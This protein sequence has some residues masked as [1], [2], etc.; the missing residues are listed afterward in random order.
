MKLRS[1]RVVAVAGLVIALGWPSVRASA[2][3]S[4]ARPE[5]AAAISVPRLIQFN[6]T[7]KDSAGRYVT[8]VS[9]VTF[10]VYAEQ[11]GGSPIWSETQNVLA[12]SDGHFAVLLGAA[13]TGAFPSALFSTTQTRWLGITVARQPEMPRVLLASVPYALKAGDADTLGGLPATSYVTTAQLA[14]RTTVAAP[15]TTVMPGGVIND[16]AGIS[17]ASTNGAPQQFGSG[18]QDATTGTGTANYLP[19]WTSSSNLGNSI[20]YQANGRIGVGT[21]SPQLTLDVNGDSIFRGSFQLPPQATATPGSG[22]PSHSFQWESS[23]YNSSTSSAQNLAFGFRAVPA[24]NN[25][26]NPTAKLDLFYG[27]GGGTLLDTGLSISNA[28][29][30]TF[31]QEQSLTASSV[32]LPNS[33]SG[34]AESLTIGGVGFLGDYGGSTNTFL[35]AKSGG[36]QLSTGTADTAIG[37][38]S[39]QNNTTGGLNVAVG[40]N[41]LQTN[42]TG[43]ANTALGFSAMQ[44]NTS[45]EGN[46]GIG[47]LALGGNKTGDYN[48]GIGYTALVYNYTG[49][50]NIAIGYQAGQWIQTGNNMTVIGANANAEDGLTNSTAIGASSFVQV[51]NA[52]VLGVPASSTVTGTAVGIGTNVPSHTLDVI[53]RGTGGSAIAASSG[54]VGDAAVSGQNYASSGYSNGAIF[55]S[56]S[57][58][59]SGVIGI[60]QAG[61]YGGYFQGNA[62]AGYFAGNVTITG[63]LV[64]GGGSFKIDDPIDPAN[65]FLSH[66]FVES[67]DMMNLYNGIVSLDA[68]GAAIVTMPEW[69][70]ALNRDFRYTLTAIGAPAP[71]IYVAEEMH[72]NQFRI[73]G[74]KK[75]QK[76]SWMVTGIRQDAWANA[77]RIPNEEEKPV[78]QQGKYL[79]PELFG[80]G[81]D[82]SIASVPSAPAQNATITTDSKTQPTGRD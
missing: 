70:S 3:T 61:G 34:S 73:A 11:D 54:I 33:K 4:E 78:D 64:K 52:I 80:A 57:P 44:D 27:P 81:P 39:L 17:P 79:H 45:G 18:S 2:Q 40:A 26:A 74:G 65:K 6:G 72:G 12:D 67:P 53:D 76:I 56:A 29:V 47:Q 16:L 51:S 7:L 82:Q 38:Y 46:I 21:T 35:G 14:A 22:Q 60:N 66:S 20:L 8:G 25:V 43:S 24:T 5:S 71:K 13:T 42:S 28:G 36:A 9:S 49:S 31:A 63:T 62:Y 48:V 37:S 23:V 68:H 10:A 32:A 50:D 55:Q 77:H 69:F 75:G 30:I 58:A 19:L 1:H 41:T 15:S 59:G